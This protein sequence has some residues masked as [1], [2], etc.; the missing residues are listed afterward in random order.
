MV[1]PFPAVARAEGNIYGAVYGGGLKGQCMFG[2]GRGK[3]VVLQI[4][5]VEH[6]IAGLPDIEG[7]DGAPFVRFSRVVGTVPAAPLLNLG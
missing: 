4:A 3:Y 6:M 1:E 2:C 5:A 7:E